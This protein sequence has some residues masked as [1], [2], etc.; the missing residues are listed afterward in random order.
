MNKYQVYRT[1]FQAPDSTA[2][3]LAAI[4]EVEKNFPGAEIVSHSISYRNVN[5][6][7]GQP[8]KELTIIYK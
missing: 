3:L 1:K 5:E 7:T 2:Y 4:R 8:F 6:P